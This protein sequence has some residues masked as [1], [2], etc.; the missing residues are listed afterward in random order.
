MQFQIPF[1]SYSGKYATKR[2]ALYHAIRDSI[3]HLVLPYRTK[4]PSSR[5]LAALYEVSR[6]TVNQVYDILSS[7]GYLSS[8]AGRGT[9][10]SYQEDRLEPQKVKEDAY[11]LSAWGER[12][13]R[14]LP[15]SWE[16]LHTDG[17]QWL[18]DFHAFASDP[19][20]FP[21][22]EW[23]RCLH[24]QARRL[25]HSDPR[26]AAVSTLGDDE[27]RECIAQ[28]LRRA[29]GIAV[30][31][32]QIAIVNGSM[33]FIALIIQLFINENDRVIVENP[34]YA[35]VRSAVQAAGG[36]C[37]PVDVDEY[38]IVPADWDGNMAFV[39]PNRQFPTGVVLPM[40]RRQQLLKWAYEKDAILIED[41]YDSE[42]RHRGKSLEPLKVLDREERVIYIGSFTK[43]LL[44]SVRIGYAVLPS[45]LVAPFAKAKALYERQP[46]NLLEQRTLAAWMQNGQ[47]ERHLRR[48]KRIYGK[49][50][51]KLHELLLSRLSSLF[52]WVAGDA[53]LHIFGWWRGAPE[54]YRQFAVQCK[55]AG[56]RWSEIETT[57]IVG[58]ER[59][60]GAYFHFPHLREEAMV[61]GVSRMEEIA[62][63]LGLQE[64]TLK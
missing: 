28:Y 8:E 53:G 33:Q 2:L 16:Q 20:W 21:G 59:R 46:T 3:I 42:F 37:V 47:Y 54:Q 12:L 27:L 17:E 1:H 48:M 55:A 57:D 7:E 30:P 13:S 18:V 31:S 56:I 26:H 38:G 61:Y 32:E 36:Q 40:E 50:F 14:V 41:D 6:G 29:R 22:D 51:Y 15:Q 39:T 44:P 52:A 45:A 62:V 63:E 49:K 19:E 34:G 11:R 23:N 60:Y 5:A 43:T 25:R 10:V 4:L 9:F 35:G 64:Q 58:R 24:E